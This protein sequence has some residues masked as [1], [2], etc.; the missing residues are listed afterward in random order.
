MISITKFLNADRRK[1]SKLRVAQILMQGIGMHAIEGDPDEYRHFR[2]SMDKAAAELEERDDSP[3]IMLQAGASI[4]ALEDYNRRTSQ[5]LRVRGDDFQS[6]VKML[7]SAIGEISTSGDQS[8]VHLRQLETK[9]AST[10]QVEDIRLLK[11]QLGICLGEIRKEAERQKLAASSVVNRLTDSLDRARTAASNDPV[12]GQ[13]PRSQALELI[14]KACKGGPPT[15]AV[16]IVVDRLQAINLSFGSEVGDQVLRY[17]A[18][19]IRRSLPSNDHLFRWAGPALLALIVRSVRIETARGEIARLMEHKL[20]Y[21]VRT[22]TRSSMI[23][24][25]ARW[26][27]FPVAAP[28]E[29]LIKKIDEF[30]ALQGGRK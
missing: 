8:V 19:S 10:S 22:A 20:E 26:A 23:P 17:F 15:L 30:A 18:G 28:S 14:A 29:D 3:E 1:D 6:M 11:T 5:Y 16:S 27:I 13:P 25:T 4:Q 2:E 24:V 9:L 12:T 21:T 7:T